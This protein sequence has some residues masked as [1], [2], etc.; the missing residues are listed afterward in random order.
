MSADL[1]LGIVLTFLAYGGL[2]ATVVHAHIVI[3]RFTRDEFEGHLP[4]YDGQPS[5][6]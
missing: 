3:R 2:I 4:G 6:E 5:D 1:I